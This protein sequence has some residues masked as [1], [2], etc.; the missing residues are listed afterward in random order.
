[1]QWRVQAGWV[2]KVNMLIDQNHVTEWRGRTP[3]T[4]VL[5]KHI[6]A[7]PCY[8]VVARNGALLQH[9]ILN[10]ISIRFAP[11]GYIWVTDSNGVALAN[12]GSRQDRYHLDSHQITTE[13]DSWLVKKVDEARNVRLRSEAQSAVDEADIKGVKVGFQDSIDAGNCNA[14][15]RAWADRHKIDITRKYDASELLQIAEH[16]DLG[17][18]RL[19]IRQAIIR[20]RKEAEE[21]AALARIDATELARLETMASEVAAVEQATQNA[22]AEI[23]AATADIAGESA[24]VATGDVTA[25]SAPSIPTS[26]ESGKAA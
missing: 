14:G 26:I 1:V 25:E 12:D 22:T 15:T 2:Q 21:Q 3:R 11:A 17:R 7:I 16:D 4:A 9:Q 10:K 18:V 24:S 23:D 20:S 5:A 13:P 19:V 8:A 6:C